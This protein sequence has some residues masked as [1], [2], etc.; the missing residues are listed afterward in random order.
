MLE[1]PLADESAVSWRLSKPGV[2]YQR[3]GNIIIKDYEG[4]RDIIS[5]DLDSLSAVAEAENFNLLV[6]WAIP[7]FEDCKGFAYQF[8]IKR[9]GEAGGPLSIRKELILSDVF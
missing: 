5:L 7:G 6:D 2:E 1:F 8:G 3:T 9:L 4:G